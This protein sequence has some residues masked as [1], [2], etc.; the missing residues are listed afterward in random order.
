MNLA[1]VVIVEALVQLVPLVQKAQRKVMLEH[2]KENVAIVVAQVPL[3]L[4]AL[5]ARQ[6]GT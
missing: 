4:P 1:N 6:V 2:K 5:K 3:V